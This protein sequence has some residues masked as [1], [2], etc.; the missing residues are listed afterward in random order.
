MIM[1]CA[2]CG[3]HMTKLEIDHLRFNHCPKCK[4]SLK[5]FYQ[6]KI[7]DHGKSVLQQESKNDVR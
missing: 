1:K 6:V 5:S 2:T 7:R 4:Q 3:Y